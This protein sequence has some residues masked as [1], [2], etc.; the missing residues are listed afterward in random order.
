M[1]AKDH[2]NL[3]PKLYNITNDFRLMLCSESTTTF[4]WPPYP[5]T[6]NGIHAI[7]PADAFR[8]AFT[9]S[10]VSF[11]RERSNHINHLEDRTLRR[12]EFPD[13][14]QVMQLNH[15]YLWRSHRMQLPMFRVLRRGNIKSC[16][17]NALLPGSNN[18]NSFHFAM[19]NEDCVAAKHCNPEHCCNV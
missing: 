11:A 10:I 6:V 19:S 5:S 2:F 18:L 3:G 9:P 7:I 12:L 17:M 8:P 15:P 14:L 4:T 16:V 1:A 13:H